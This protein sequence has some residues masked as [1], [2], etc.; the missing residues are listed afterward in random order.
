VR[1]LNVSIVLGSYEMLLKLIVFCFIGLFLAFDENRDNC[2]D[3]K[4]MACGISACCLG[5]LV[6][7]Y[8]CRFHFFVQTTQND[9]SQYLISDVIPV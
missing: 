1:F 2:I 9:P 3:F 7:R 6:E 8:K 4:E 5:P